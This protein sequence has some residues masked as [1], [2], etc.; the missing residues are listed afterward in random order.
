MLAD[1]GNRFDLLICDE[2]HHLP[3]PSYRQIPLL[4][5]AWYRLGLTATY[6]RQDFAHQELDS[7]AR[8]GGLQTRI[9]DLKGEYLADYEI[10]R[11]H[12]TLTDDELARY[13]A[14]EA[15]LPAFLRASGITP[16]GSGMGDFL[17]AAGTCRG[18]R[19]AAG[20]IRDAADRHRVRAQTQRAGLPA[21]TAL[22]G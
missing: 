4:S 12:T 3:A 5:T 7:S 13:S 1:Y 9:K 11:L 17:K 20:E 10:V 8:P 2:V 14:C 16:F 6:E 18:A 15:A 19:G 22:A 21:E